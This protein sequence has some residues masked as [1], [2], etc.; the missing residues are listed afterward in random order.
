[1]QLVI[2]SRVKSGI[3]ERKNLFSV[4][5]LGRKVLKSWRII[6][7]PNS[8]QTI[9]FQEYPQIPKGRIPKRP[10]GSKDRI[11]KSLNGCGSRPSGPPRTRFCP[12]CRAPHTLC[13]YILLLCTFHTLFEKVLWCVTLE[14]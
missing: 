8:C 10:N 9:N 2:S 6:I 1:M 5:T 14:K 11:P 3:L 12:L 13:I 7:S 4:N